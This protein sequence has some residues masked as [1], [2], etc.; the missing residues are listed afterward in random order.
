MKITP[1][2]LWQA[3]ETLVE[4]IKHIRDNEEF[5]DFHHM[6][7]LALRTLI[8]MVA[9]DTNS[10]NIDELVKAVADLI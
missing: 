8:L 4:A 7:N 2:D 9:A 6:D 1:E 3:N 10:H 5:H